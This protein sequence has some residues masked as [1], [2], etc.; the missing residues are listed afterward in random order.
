MIRQSRSDKTVGA[1]EDQ[2]GICLNARR[3]MLLGNLLNERGF[4]S[5]S[6]L[7][8]AFRGNATEH[9][10]KRRSFLSFHSED[11]RQIQ[12]FKLMGLNKN[13]PV[14]FYDKSLVEPINSENSSYVKSE[15]SEYIRA[16][17]I[18]ICMIG[19]GTVGRDW[20]DWE[21]RK[22]QEFRKGICGIRLK[23]SRGKR[24][25]FLVEI[26]APVASWDTDEMVAVIECAAAR[27]S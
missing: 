9:A 20:V 12:G 11:L 18:V 2:Y 17:E 21:L 4:E 5:W 25:P 3:D 24:P 13:V 26:K 10:K 16:A 14:S 15:L 1:L 7:Y 19:D 23:D 8:K 6:Q 22:A 27:R